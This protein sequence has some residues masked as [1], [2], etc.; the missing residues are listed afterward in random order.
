MWVSRPVTPPED[1]ACLFISPIPTVVQRLTAPAALHPDQC[2]DLLDCLAQ[3]AH[4]R[5]RRGRRHG[6]HGA[7]GRGGRDAC[8]LRQ[9]ST[10]PHDELTIAPVRV[11][12]SSEATN[13]TSLAVSAN[14]GDRRSSV[15][16]VMISA[17]FSLGTP[18][19]S[20][21]SSIVCCPTRVSVISA[22]RTHT[23]RTPN[24]LRSTARDLIRDSMAP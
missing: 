19:A 9:S 21:P 7:G 5:H 10:R 24:G 2:H 16:E 23:T 6:R 14:V 3:V 22:G 1:R 11:F 15:L 20:A 18:M 12:A 4:P 17:I 13:V 8:R